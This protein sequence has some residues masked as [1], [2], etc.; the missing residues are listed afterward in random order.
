MPRS[1]P[2]SAA[3]CIL[4]GPIHAGRRDQVLHRCRFIAMHPERLHGACQRLWL[5]RRCRTAELRHCCTRSTSGNIYK[6]GVDAQ[7]RT[8]RS[9]KPNRRSLHTGHLRNAEAHH[10]R[11]PGYRTVPH[12]GFGNVGPGEHSLGAHR[13]ISFLD[14]CEP[15]RELRSPDVSKA[16]VCLSRYAPSK[17]RLQD[18]NWTGRALRNVESDTHDGVNSLRIAKFQRNS[19]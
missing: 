1:R 17:G 4:A 7:S 14:R 9:L 13:Q 10:L 12:L 18:S 6:D 11:N 15:C 16:A 2:V 19:V 8:G 5:R 3:G